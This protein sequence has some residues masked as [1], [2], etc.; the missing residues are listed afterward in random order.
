LPSTT[1]PAGR[2]DYLRQL[3]ALLE[4]PQV[5][6][7]ALR[8]AGDPDVAEDALAEAYCAMVRVADPDRIVDV[9]AYF[10]RVLIHEIYRLRGQLGATPTDD[11]A[12]LA[13]ASAS[14]AGGRAPFDETVTMRMLVRTWLTC[15]TAQR[16]MLV[17]LVPGRSPNP[18]RYRAVIVSAAGRLLLSLVTGDANEADIS[19]ALRT[20]YPEW[21]AAG[22]CEAGNAYQRYSR[23]R[24][25]IY[26]VLRN[27]VSRE[28]LYR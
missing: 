26:Q 18:G 28:D 19:V 1:T 9:R 3:Q 11:I 24:A 5:R 23:A 27:I 16:H 15:L 12:A 13:D 21:F 7:I 25:D 17:A 10:C 2:P 8:R 20:A 4:D 22:G 14:V 6:R